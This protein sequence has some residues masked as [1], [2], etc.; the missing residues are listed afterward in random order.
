MN[1]PLQNATQD[2]PLMITFSWF[3]DQEME[4]KDS[5]ELLQIFVRIL[6]KFKLLGDLVTD[7]Q[8]WMNGEF[9]FTGY[10]TFK[11]FDAY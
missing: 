7:A 8:Y 10:M 11:S 6:N 2:A 1:R 4:Q 5:A 3:E 9:G